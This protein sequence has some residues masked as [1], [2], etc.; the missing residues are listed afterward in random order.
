MN[1]IALYFLLLLPTEY[2]HSSPLKQ[3]TY[4]KSN[5]AIQNIKLFSLRNL[6][7]SSIHPIKLTAL[8]C[9]FSSLFCLSSKPCQR[10]IDF[11]SLK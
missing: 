9:P 7:F 3:C 11:F 4:D 2:P 1:N 6:S 8:E 5:E 10:P